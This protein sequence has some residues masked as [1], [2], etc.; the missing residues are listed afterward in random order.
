MPGVPGEGFRFTRARVVAL[1]AGVAVAFAIVSLPTPL[2]HFGEFG[3][4]PAIAAAVTA[5]MSIWWLSEALPIYVTACVPVLADPLLRVFG[6]TASENV[7]AT[8][9]A[10]LDPYIFLFA[11]GMAIAAAAEHKTKRRNDRAHATHDEDE[12]ID[13]ATASNEAG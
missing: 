9:R 10:Y 6:P 5:L 7:R 3:T 8:A 2:A 4:R 12:E 1:F 13:V 11:G